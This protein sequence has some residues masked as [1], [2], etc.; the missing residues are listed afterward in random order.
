MFNLELYILLE[1]KLD[2]IKDKFSNEIGAIAE[3][4]NI[5]NSGEQLLNALIETDPTNN[6]IYA[7][8]LIYQFIRETL[9]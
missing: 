3:K 2:V 9:V 6:K 1:G 7:Q 5:P 4:N 8:W